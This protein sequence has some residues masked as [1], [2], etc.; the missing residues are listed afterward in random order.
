MFKVGLTGG[1][2]SGKSTVSTMFRNKGLRVLDAD[3]IA[4]EV[5][6]LYP[7][8]KE[9]IKREFGQ[10]FFDDVGALKRKELG[11]Y[12]FK[13]PKERVKLDAI[14][15]P[16]IKEEI[17]KRLKELEDSGVG[18]CILDAPTL[19]EHRIHE[20]MDMNIVV[21][22]DRNTQIDRIKKRD[23]LNNERADNRLNAQMS[24]EEKR[25]FANFIIDNSGSIENTRQQV[26]EIVEVLS[27]YR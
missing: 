8:L 13:Y 6:Q 9:S 25:A 12:I 21:W 1:I 10:H 14:M 26:Q 15:I 17:F 3:V 11:D 18:L 5:L 16:V 23:G 22:A 27:I 7:K 24:L 20:D 2:G 4:R 19:I